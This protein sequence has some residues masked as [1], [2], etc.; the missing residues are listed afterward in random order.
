MKGRVT[1]KVVPE[2]VES[3]EIAPPCMLT[4]WRER[5]RPMPEPPLLVV[6]KGRKM[7]SAASGLIPHPL[8]DTEIMN[9]WFGW[10]PLVDTITVGF[11]SMDSTA[12]FIRFMST[13]SIWCRSS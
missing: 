11:S 13:C 1:V 5:L 2:E 9:L 10:S 12:F 6:K 4:I 7:L 8:S 3:K